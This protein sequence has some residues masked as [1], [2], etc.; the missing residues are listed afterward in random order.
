MASRSWYGELRDTIKCLH[1][2]KQ[3]VIGSFG[4]EYMVNCGDPRTILVVSMVAL[5]NAIPLVIFLIFAVISS[6]VILG[7]AAIAL[8]IAVVLGTIVYLPIL[9]FCTVA[10]AVAS[11]FVLLISCFFES[12]LLRHNESMPLKE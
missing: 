10:G 2:G 6:T 12:K 9:F 4:L 8:C 7:S 11:G 1:K 5:F 3:F